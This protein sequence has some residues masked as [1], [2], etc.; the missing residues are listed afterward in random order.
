MERSLFE[1]EVRLGLDKTGGTYLSRIPSVDPQSLLPTPTWN[2]EEFIFK[3]RQV[4][5]KEISYCLVR[6][7]AH[8]SLL[9]LQ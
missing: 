3:T 1:P 8:L 2:E 9:I 6:N 4:D 7:C 5:R